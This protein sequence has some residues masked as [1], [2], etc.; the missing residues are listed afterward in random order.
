MQDGAHWGSCSC[1]AV[2]PV[3]PLSLLQLR[4]DIRRQV[5]CEIPLG[6]D[7]RMQSFYPRKVEMDDLRKPTKVTR[8]RGI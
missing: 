1:A 6:W 4:K 8:D 7:D 2:R 5:D 3:Y